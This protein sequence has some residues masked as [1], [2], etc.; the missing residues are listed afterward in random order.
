MFRKNFI[1][2]QKKT[3]SNDVFDVKKKLQFYQK[4]VKILVQKS[5]FYDE[6]NLKF[7]VL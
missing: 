2:Q 4:K 1:F 7:E 5:R 3:G 6:G